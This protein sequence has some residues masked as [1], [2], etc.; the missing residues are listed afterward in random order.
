MGKVSGPS[1]IYNITFMSLDG[2]L[3]G[4]VSSRSLP[5]QRVPG[6]IPA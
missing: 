4:L 5:A 1:E 3:G 6:S 2:R